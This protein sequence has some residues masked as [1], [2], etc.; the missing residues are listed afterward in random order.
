MNYLWRRILKRSAMAKSSMM[1]KIWKAMNKMLQRFLWLSRRTNGRVKVAGRE[2]LCPMTWSIRHLHCGNKVTNPNVTR[3]T[4]ILLKWLSKD[5]TIKKCLVG[6]STMSFWKRLKTTN[7]RKSTL[8]KFLANGDQKLWRNTSMKLWFSRKEST[9]KC[10]LTKKTIKICLDQ[11]L[12]TEEAHL[13][14]GTTNQNSLRH[15][16]TETDGKE[17]TR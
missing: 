4:S 7:H 14:T 13:K 2:H 15:S 16:W 11:G 10:I 5:P 3:A 12:S 6:Q 8:L 9:Q 17:M 1:P